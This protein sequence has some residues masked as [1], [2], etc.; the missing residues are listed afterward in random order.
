MLDKPVLAKLMGIPL[1]RHNI[2]VLLVTTTR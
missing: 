1:K 2:S